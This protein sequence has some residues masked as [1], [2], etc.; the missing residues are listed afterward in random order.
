MT[1]EHRILITTNEVNKPT[2]YTP[3][4]FETEVADFIAT[5]L[6]RGADI[7]HYRNINYLV[8]IETDKDGTISKQTY[9]WNG[10]TRTY[11]AS[12]I[13]PIVKG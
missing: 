7:R 11:E 3:F 2:A 8:D 4:N 5:L 10:P 13:D 9:R 6:K 1:T 12:G